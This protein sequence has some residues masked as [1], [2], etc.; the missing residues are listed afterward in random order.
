MLTNTL[1]AP[2]LRSEMRVHELQFD[3]IKAERTA[4][5]KSYSDAFRLLSRMTPAD[6]AYFDGL[7]RDFK[8]AEAACM[9][10]WYNQHTDIN[11]EQY[12]NVPDERKGRVRQFRINTMNY[13]VEVF[14]QA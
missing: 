14:N 12:R 10:I 6:K 11:H 7:E 1:L 13:W 8:K 9:A 3:A 2:A 4:F 5:L